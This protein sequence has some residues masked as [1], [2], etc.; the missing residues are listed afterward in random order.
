MSWRVMALCAALVFSVL[1]LWSRLDSARE[2]VDQLTRQRDALAVKLKRQ[3]DQT[4]SEQTTA[5]EG[6]ASSQ[7]GN[8]EQEATRIEI[9][10]KIIHEPCANQSVPDDVAGRVWQLA[11]RARTNALPAV[12]RQPDGVTGSPAAGR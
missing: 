6:L 9:V 12:T 2:Q 3:A 1:F 7:Q 5:Q 10:E 4:R 11:G 8:A